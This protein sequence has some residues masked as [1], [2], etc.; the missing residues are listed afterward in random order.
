[1]SI[2]VINVY[3]EFKMYL[4]KSQ[5]AEAHISNLMSSQLDRFSQFIDA[6]ERALSEYDEVW[7]LGDVNL[8]L[9]KIKKDPNS[10][11]KDFLRL[12]D[13]RIFSSGVNQ[14]IDGITWTRDNGLQ[15]SCID[16]IYT[17]CKSYLGVSIADCNFSDHKLISVVRPNTSKF[18]RMPEMKARSFK[19]F[20]YNDYDWYLRTS[21]LDSVLAENDPEHQVLKLTAI[22][23][24]V[25]DMTCPVVKFKNREFHT[26]WMTKD[27]QEV[28]DSRD[29]I[30][31]QYRYHLANHGQSDISDELYKQYK[32]KKNY[33]E[34]QFIFYSAA[35]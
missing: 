4:P 13:D 34:A 35:L 21:D 26:K 19:N 18:Q 7:V 25:A 20:V 28:I 16:H 29:R 31:S 5:R 27:L 15:N 12:I 10:D 14:L 23:N 8:D 3:R 17:N 6:W 33:K 1:M 2:L 24:V 9:K 22:M 11:K 30:Y 32:V